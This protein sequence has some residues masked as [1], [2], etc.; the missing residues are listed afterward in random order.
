MHP[1]CALIIWL[2][3]VLA[4]QALGYGGVLLL[5]AG[6]LLLGGGVLRPW[7]GYVRRARWLLLT[8]WLILAYNVPG[9]AFED[10]SWAPTYEGIADANL[11]ALRLIVMLGCLAWLFHR[12]GRDGLVSAL[13]GLLRPCRAIGLDT[14]RLVVR[15]SLV[16]DNLQTPQEKGAWRNMLGRQV[17][18]GNGPTILHLALPRWAVRDSL[19]AGLVA[20]GLLGVFVA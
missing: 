17:E 10:Y 6:V 9:E 18:H 12:L 7:W 5:A 20:V 13:W 1:S 16:L 4:L 11:H 19:L 14:E 3:S 8:L 15:L 2:A